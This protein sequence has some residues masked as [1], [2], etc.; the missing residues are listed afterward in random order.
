MCKCDVYEVCYIL[1]SKIMTFLHQLQ[2]KKI[3]TVKEKFCFYESLSQV[4]PSLN[5]SY[6]GRQLKNVGTMYYNF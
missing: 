5:F 6:K 1:T 2:Y 4:V 3:P